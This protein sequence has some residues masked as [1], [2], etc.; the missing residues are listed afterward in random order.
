M[1]TLR[2]E[3]INNCPYYKDR[4]PIK[5]WLSFDCT[6]RSCLSALAFVDK[7]VTDL[8]TSK[9]F[10][11]FMIIVLN[12]ASKRVDLNLSPSMESYFK[13]TFSRNVFV[14]CVAFIG[15][16]HIYSAFIVTALFVL[17]RDYLFNEDSRFSILPRS[18]CAH[19]VE[20]MEN[21]K[22]TSEPPDD[23]AG[24]KAGGAEGDSALI[25]A[26]IKT[27]QAHGFTVKRGEPFSKQGNGFASAA[28]S[29]QNLI[30]TY[31]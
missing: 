25:G 3:W 23:D 8:N 29:N 7:Q 14:F 10:I 20:M 12:I 21:Q 17:F 4:M 9:V 15:C 24:A 5:N 22:K 16:R 26:L 6:S 2:T 30:G 11:A 31:L 19:H 13:H 28:Q 27:L 18:F 1:K